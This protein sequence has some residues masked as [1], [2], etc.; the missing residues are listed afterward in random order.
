[1]S[2]RFSQKSLTY[3]FLFM[4]VY[5]AWIFLGIGFRSD[6]LPLI[7][8]IAI[9]YI[10]S[11]KSHRFLIGFFALAMSWVLLDSLRIFPSFMYN[12]VHIEEIYRAEIQFFGISTAEG[13]TI[14]PNEY[15]KTIANPI[16]DFITGFTYLMWT[17]VP[18]I[19]GFVLFLKNRNLLLRFSICFFLTNVIG[20]IIYYSYP[21]APPWYVDLYGFEEHFDIPGSAAGLLRFDEMTGTNIF[22]GIYSKSFNVF[23]AVPSLHSAYPLISTYYAKKHGLKWGTILLVIFTIMTWFSAVYSIHHYVIDVVLGIFCAIFAIAFFEKILLKTKV[24][25]LIKKL[26][27]YIT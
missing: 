11:E 23:G 18:F 22:E 25:D 26:T 6:H 14:T 3:Y 20:V 9:T 13:M 7:L 15:L 4:S 8:I 17:P 2:N 27:I 16:L 10:Y 5:L 21:A 24:D 19:F 12:D 1:M